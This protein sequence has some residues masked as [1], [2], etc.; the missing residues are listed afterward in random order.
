[1][2]SSAG[3][4]A[5]C[6]ALVSPVAVS[7]A[8]C[9]PQNLPSTVRFLEVSHRSADK[10]VAVELIADALKVELSRVACVGDMP[11]DLPM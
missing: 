11:N 1:M 5:R 2:P 8:S 9:A 4:S 10:G 7:V 6:R 3:W